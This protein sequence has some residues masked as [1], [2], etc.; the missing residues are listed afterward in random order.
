MPIASS[1]PSRAHTLAF[2]PDDAGVR[3]HRA[4]PARTATAR[5]MRQRWNVHGDVDARRDVTAVDVQAGSPAGQPSVSTRMSERHASTHE[6]VERRRREEAVPALERPDRSECGS[7]HSSG[8]RS[9]VSDALVEV[10]PELVASARCRGFAEPLARSAAPTRARTSSGITRARA[11]GR[12]AAR[13]STPAPRRSGWSSCVIETRIDSARF[14]SAQRRDLDDRRRR[15]SAT[16][17]KWPTMLAGRSNRECAPA[18]R[19]AIDG[20]VAAVRS[21]DLPVARQ[22]A[23]SSDRRC[24]ST[25]GVG[26]EVA[27]RRAHLATYGTMRSGLRQASSRPSTCSVR[28]S[29]SQPPMHT[30]RSRI[31]AS[32]NDAARRRA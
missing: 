1:A 13:T 21:P 30:V 19:S 6:V 14:A 9:S 8:R 32:V 3:A 18:A 5:R 2:A 7:S 15:T 17:R 31:S 23:P 10:R 11:R 27:H 29:A 22:P 16:P 20:D 25:V 4:S 24:P 26:R 28:P 12:R